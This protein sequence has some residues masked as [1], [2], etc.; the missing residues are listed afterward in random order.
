MD[1]DQLKAQF[2]DKNTL[3]ECFESVIWQKGRRCPHYDWLS[4]YLFSGRS[5]RPGL[6]EL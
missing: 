2:A 4:C 6:Y 5:C 3:R 1:I